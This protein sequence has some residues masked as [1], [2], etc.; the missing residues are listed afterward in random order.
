MNQSQFSLD[1][2]HTAIPVPE[3]KSKRVSGLKSGSR[4][5]IC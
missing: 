1:Y 3:P 2:Y 4:R 5:L